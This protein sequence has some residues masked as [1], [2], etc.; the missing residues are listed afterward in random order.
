ME[1]ET[2]G[3]AGRGGKGG[4]RGGKGRGKPPVVGEDGV[5]KRGAQLWTQA[6]PTLIRNYATSH[7]NIIESADVQV[8][9]ETQTVTPFQPV[10]TQ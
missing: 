4:E 9:S 10:T 2:S 1:S 6:V 8:R 7:S 3:K 5:P